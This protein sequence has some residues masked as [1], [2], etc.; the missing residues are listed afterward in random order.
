MSRLQDLTPAQ[1]D[2]QQ[3]Y[4]YSAVATG[5]RAAGP[6]LFHL[7]DD[8]GALTGPFN[9]LLHAPE[10][11]REVQQVGERL[12]FSG[13]LPATAREAVILA[14]ART[15]SSEFE[16]Y[17]HALVARS[18]GL[19]K[20][21]IAALAAGGE[22]AFAEEPVRVAV[23]VAGHLLGREAVPDAV[24][25]DAV[26]LFGESGLVELAVLVGYYQLLAG[27]LQMFQVGLPEGAE[28]FFAGKPSHHQ[29]GEGP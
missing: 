4:L 29:P 12:R 27:V 5:K 18:V 7:V 21:E 9:A 8:D 3:R 17:V 14:V 20:S 10:L 28:P 25:A 15:W 24:Y 22:L 26:R 1:L 13:A 23:A 19:P 2:D 16:W 6:Q 11:G